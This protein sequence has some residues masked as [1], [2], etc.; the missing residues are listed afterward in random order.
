VLDF[1][2][3]SGRVNGSA[4]LGNICLPLPSSAEMAAHTACGPSL[5]MELT[6]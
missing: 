4:F 5:A 2:L 3:Y 1:K 6:A